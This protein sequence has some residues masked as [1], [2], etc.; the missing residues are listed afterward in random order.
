[1]KLVFCEVLEGRMADDGWLMTGFSLKMFL[2]VVE[3]PSAIHHL[4]S[5]IHYHS[6]QQRPTKNHKRHRKVNDQAGNI[7]EG[8][9]KGGGADS[10]VSAETF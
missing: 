9:D 10:G 4:P 6:L 2:L 8:G 5:L 3:P 1:M 7:H